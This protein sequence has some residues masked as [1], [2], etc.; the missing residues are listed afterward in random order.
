MKILI[1]IILIIAWITLFFDTGLFIY[2]SLS[3]SLLWGVLS[4][5]T[6]SI[7]WLYYIVRK[8]KSYYTNGIWIIVLYISFL[9]FHSFFVETEYYRLYYYL[10]GFAFLL[11]IYHSC[12]EKIIF[13]STIKKLSI[14]GLSIQ[15]VVILGQTLQFWES[16]SPY[17]IITGCYENPNVAAM[18]IA[19]IIPFIADDIYNKR[20]IIPLSGLLILSLVALYLLN[21]RTAWLV[22]T[23]PTLIFVIRPVFNAIKRKGLRKIFTASCLTFFVIF[24]SILYQHKYDSSNGRRLIWELSL[25]EIISN[26][27]GNGYGRFASVYN[28]IQSDYFRNESSSEIERENARYTAMAY[29]DYLENGVDGGIGGLF[30]HVL[31]ILIFIILSYR[32]RNKVTFSIFLMVATMSCVNFVIISILPWIVFLMVAGYTLSMQQQRITLPI[33]K[34]LSY[35]FGMLFALFLCYKQVLFIQGQY[36]LA[37]PQTKVSNQLLLISDIIGTSEAY[38]RTVAQYYIREK[39]WEKAILHCNEALLYTSQP[40]VLIMKAHALL[41]KNKI[42]EA[43]EVLLSLRYM[44]PTQLKCK[45]L[46]LQLYQK[47][48]M[49]EKAHEIAHEILAVKQK[50]LSQETIRIQKVAQE[51]LNHIHHE[52]RHNK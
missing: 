11:L 32:Q 50:T 34:R 16:K 49:T 31:L 46:L 38:H 48:Q 51:Y 7:I 1:K 40:S 10:S 52:Y 3:M 26:P 33:P 35:L 39:D 43:E 6:L 28:N 44:I 15:L 36:L 45:L 29:N 42:K 24:M 41:Q 27:Q 13:F 20:H 5:F 9:L 17:F 22:I 25:K 8:S 19:L 2:P 4:C 23:I 47:H 14:I 12:I 18:Y 30:L 21:C 37:K